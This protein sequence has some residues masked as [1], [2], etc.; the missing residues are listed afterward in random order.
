MRNAPG[1]EPWKCCRS[2]TS[3]TRSTGLC[4]SDEKEPRCCL[5]PRSSQ[6]TTLRIV[7][8][9]HLRLE[10]KH[11]ERRSPSTFRPDLVTSA[12]PL[13][14]VQHR[15]SER[16]ESERNADPMFRYTFSYARY[17]LTALSTIAFKLAA[18]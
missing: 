15:L 18:N 13:P 1:S 14:T 10:F 9:P 3:S 7:L 16:P 2:I 8:A 6:I 17:V 12:T 5:K 11:T 4:R